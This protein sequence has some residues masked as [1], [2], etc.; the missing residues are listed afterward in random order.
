MCIGQRKGAVEKWGNTEEVVG[1]KILISDAQTWTAERD[2]K[3]KTLLFLQSLG[4][5]T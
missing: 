1:T 2:S 3:L 5:L 4:Q